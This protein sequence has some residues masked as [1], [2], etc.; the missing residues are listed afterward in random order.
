MKTTLAALLA[1]AASS[2]WG[3]SQVAGGTLEKD[4]TLAIA[5]KL[6]AA[7]ANGLGLQA[8]LTGSPA[9]PPGTPD[10]R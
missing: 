5:R 8:F 4:V 1:L 10:L 9:M 2:A 6:R 7:I 3:Q